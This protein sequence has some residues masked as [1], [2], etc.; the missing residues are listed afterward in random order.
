MPSVPNTANLIMNLVTGYRIATGFIM[1]TFSG[2]LEITLEMFKDKTRLYE[3][4]K[5]ITV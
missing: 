1:R 5:M 4:E 2:L 3:I